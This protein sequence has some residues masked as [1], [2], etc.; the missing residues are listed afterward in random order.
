MRWSH[1]RCRTSISCISHV[2]H[3][4]YNVQHDVVCCTY[5]I[6]RHARTVGH[7]V[8]VRHRR[9]QE[10]ESTADGRAARGI[11]ERILQL[12]WGVFKMA[13]MADGRHVSFNWNLSLR[14][15][16]LELGTVTLK[17]ATDKSWISI[18]P[19]RA[20]SASI[21]NVNI[22]FALNATFSIGFW[23]GLPDKLLLQG[24]GPNAKPSEE[25]GKVPVRTCN[26]L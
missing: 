26:S 25:F 11:P 9:W 13:P 7:R 6:V 3:R 24:P 17:C 8:Y 14:K 1:V 5:D 22:F 21:S 23:N 10:S 2:R 16:K 12:D 15:F 19:T 4:T 20:F 18:P